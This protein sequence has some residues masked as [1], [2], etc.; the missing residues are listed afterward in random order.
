MLEISLCGAYGLYPATNSRTLTRLC[1]LLGSDDKKSI[2]EKVRTNIRPALV[3]RCKTAFYNAFQKTLIQDCQQKG[4]PPLMEVTWKGNK[5]AKISVEKR[6]EDSYMKY[7]PNVD[8]ERSPVGEYRKYWNLRR[9]GDYLI[10]LQDAH[11]TMCGYSAQDFHSLRF[12]SKEDTIK[13]VISSIPVPLL[14][15]YVCQ[16]RNQ[17]YKYHTHS[18]YVPHKTDKS[19]VCI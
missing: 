19:I 14:A 1:Q 12:S 11:I 8:N 10:N 13:S 6:V 7:I 16:V 9:F 3:C 17:V 18:F 2:I 4:E 15:F 5:I